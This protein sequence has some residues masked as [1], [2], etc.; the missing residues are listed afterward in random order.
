MLN[1]SLTFA[2]RAF[3]G[4]AASLEYIL[5]VATLNAFGKKLLTDIISSNGPKLQP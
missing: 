3:V 1:F 2:V 4:R 5:I